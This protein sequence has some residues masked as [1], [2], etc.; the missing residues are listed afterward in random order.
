MITF[1]EELQKLSPERRRKIED[2][3]QELLCQARAFKQLQEQLGISED[4]IV[5]FLEQK[6]STVFKLENLDNQITLAKLSRVV[7]A[8]GGQYELVLKLPSLEPITLASSDAIINDFSL[9]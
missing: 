6:Q 2:K 7:A 9:K 5:E 3:T 4:D 1:D 8:L